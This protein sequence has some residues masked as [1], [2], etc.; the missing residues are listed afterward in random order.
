MQKT[1][2]LQKFTLVYHVG[3]FVM[4]LAIAT[5]TDFCR[6][7]TQYQRT[8]IQK[9]VEVRSHERVTG[10]YISPEMFESFKMTM[11][12]SRKSYTLSNLP[13][14]IKEKMA[15]AKMDARYAHLDSLMD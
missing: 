6:N 2:K 10:Y 13:Q 3:V 12:Q 15:E 1:C 14:N 9:P 8:V 5:A 7:F 11:L 4:V